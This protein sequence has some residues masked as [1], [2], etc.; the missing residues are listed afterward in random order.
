M[1]MP[2]AAFRVL[3]LAV[4]ASGPSRAQTV[5]DPWGTCITIPP[6]TSSSAET[7]NYE[8]PERVDPE[9]AARR[10]RKAVASHLNDEGV[11]AWDRGDWAQAFLLFDKALTAYPY[12]PEPKSMVRNY[13]AALIK[14]V[15]GDLDKGEWEHAEYLCRSGLHYDSKSEDLKRL[16]VVVQ[17]KADEGRA[18]KAVQARDDQR[19]QTART[20]A[21]QAQQ[22]YETGD[23]S[24]AESLALKAASIYPEEPSWMQN[25]SVYRNR[26][27]DLVEYQGLGASREDRD[28]EAIRYFES[29]MELYQGALEA[30]PQNAFASKMSKNMQDLITWQIEHRDMKNADVLRQSK[31][32]RDAS[33]A[34]T[35][36][37]PTGLPKDQER[38]IAVAYQHS[39]PGV[40]ERV[41]RGFQAVNRSDW[42]LARAWFGDALNRDPNNT[43]L[44]NM[45]TLVDY[46][47]GEVLR[48]MPKSVG[49][50][51]VPEPVPDKKEI[52]AFFTKFREG[53]H[54]EPS[55]A[56]RRYVRS[57]SNDEF[58][59]LLYNLQPAET[60][61]EYLFGMVGAAN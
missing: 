58:V 18:K 10:D 53:R 42:V 25:V 31:A 12:R 24:L 3:I 51:L 49:T 36:N 20:F 14:V 41:Q 46:A 26:Q 55:D 23:Y 8:P 47:Q 21:L 1:K 19:F 16:C 48:S 17:Q 54:Q 6:H 34:G 13:M 22:A 2:L 59:N 28:D 9:E 27:G 5:C 39:P 52:E 37:L 45:L 30:N 7:P 38:A 56:V 40:I 32:N 11:A 4:L 61:L 15:E 35:A 43:G 60:D 33:L 57:L 29:A 44:N 50:S